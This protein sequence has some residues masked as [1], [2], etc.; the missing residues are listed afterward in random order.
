VVFVFASSGAA[1]GFDRASTLQLFP[2]TRIGGVRVGSTTVA[3]AASI[4]KARLLPP[5]HRPIELRAPHLAIAVDAWKL[6]MRVDVDDAVRRTLSDQRSTPFLSRVWRRV[7]GEDRN[8]AV[9]PTLNRASLHAVV[10]DIAKRVNRQVRDARVEVRG[11]ELKLFPDQIGRD[12]NVAGAERHIVRALG[13]GKTNIGLPVQVTQPQIPTSAF[14]KAILVRTISNTLTFYADGKIKKRYAVATGTGGYPTPHGQFQI[15]LKRMHP[16][17]VNPHAPWS[18]GMP[19]YIPPGP[20]NPLGTR[21]MNLSA[22][23]IRIH[24][25]PDDGSIG[26]NASHGCIRM[27]IHDAEELFEMVDVGTPV[28]II[29]A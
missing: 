7:W 5:L 15:T 18:A 9:E 3:E 26:S 11:D 21:A 6:G 10:A 23:G 29:A 20:N 14:K 2:G 8:I 27:H 24:G 19:E 17:W 25:T 13:L 12:M 4:V 16:S 22:S 1:V 28:V